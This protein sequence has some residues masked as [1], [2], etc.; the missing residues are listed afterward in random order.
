MLYLLG[1]QGGWG[2]LALKEHGHEEEAEEH[3]HLW[4]TKRSRSRSRVPAKEHTRN[5]PTPDL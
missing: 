2:G 5:T 3:E 1:K 4:N